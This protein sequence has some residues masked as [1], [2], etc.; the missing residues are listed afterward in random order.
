[1]LLA[2]GIMFT[3]L[4]LF[5]GDSVLAFISEQL[6][7]RRTY[8]LELEREQTRRVESSNAGTPSSGASSR[9]TVSSSATT[10]SHERPAAGSDATAAPL[11]CADSSPRSNGAVPPWPWP[12]GC[13][14]RVLRWLHQHC[15]HVGTPA[16]SAAVSRIPASTARS[17]PCR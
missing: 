6:E 5:V 1:M 13:P 7:R 16:G 12:G 8:R 15:R 17:D 9:A 3:V 11:F 14:R 2:A 10:A 4:A